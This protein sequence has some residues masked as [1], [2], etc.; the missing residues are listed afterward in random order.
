M[1]DRCNPSS[2]WINLALLGMTGASLGLL[3]VGAI[4]A[5]RA[6]KDVEEAAAA[7]KQ[8]VGAVNKLGKAAKGWGL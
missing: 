5:A 7:V 8:A 1:T 6:K 2:K 4:L 3:V